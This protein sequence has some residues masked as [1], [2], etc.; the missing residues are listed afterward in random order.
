[1]LLCS[2][3]TAA[4]ILQID[5]DGQLT[6]VI[7][8]FV[9]SGSFRETYDVSFQDGRC[10]DLFSGCDSNLDDLFPI[11]IHQSAGTAALLA[12]LG[13]FADAPEMIRGCES[14]V[15]C[16]IT[17]PTNLNDAGPSGG[18]VSGSVGVVRSGQPNI[19][20]N[21]SSSASRFTDFGLI[22]NR[23][24]GVWTPSNLREPP[25]GGGS[26][27]TAVAEPAVFPLIIIGLLISLARR[28]ASSNG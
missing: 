9:E 1:M 10:V 28:R 11:N 22:A 25:D 8:I 5:A 16:F 26:D 3:A 19:S 15:D 23:V 13:V 17:S 4:P 24:Y 14:E 21:E 7:D 27:P 18:N 6:G 12:V 20:I 2:A